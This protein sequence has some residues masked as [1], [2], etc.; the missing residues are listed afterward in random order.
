MSSNTPV[1]RRMKLLW[2]SQNLPYPPKTG[3]LQRNYNLIR[4]ASRFADVVLVGIV[5]EDILPEFDAAIAEQEL[6]KLCSLVIPVRMPIESSRSLFYSVV[7]KSLFTRAPFTVNWATAPELRDALK[8]AMASGPFD[9]VYFDTISLADYRHQ[10]NGTAIAL[11]HHN[12]ESHLFERRIGYEQN[13]LKRFYFRQEAAKLRRYEQDVVSDFDTHLVVSTLDGD[14][15]REI[16]P[17]ISTSVVANGVDTD[18]F[19]SAGRRPEH[20]HLVMISGMNW[21]PNRDAVLFMIE[22]IWPKLS[23]TLPEAKLTIVGASPPP[24]VLNL[25]ARDSRVAVT[26]FVSDVRPYMERAQVYLCP[27]RDGGGTRL[28]ILDSLAM[29]MPIVST[30]MGLE[31]IDLQPE[32]DALIADSPDEFVNQVSRLVKDPELCATLSAN[33]RK[34]VEEHFS[35]EAIGRRMERIFSDISQGR[36]RHV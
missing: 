20:G 33:G 21:F 5:K 30:T 10:V 29:A 34:F 18:Y 15:L 7:L 16:K 6:R 9:A 8:R 32:R 36:R 23:S 27:M 3:V 13:P 22:S 11:N 24:A 2:V 17:G 26:G 19:R 4:E 12:I 28:K 25:A 31:G 14:R 35:W 1:H